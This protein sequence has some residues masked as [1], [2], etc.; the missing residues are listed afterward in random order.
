[1]LGDTGNSMEAVGEKIRADAYYAQSDGL[2][3]VAI[4]LQNFTGRIYIEATLISDPQE[5]DWFP[6]IL[7]GGSAYVE[8][9]LIPG[10]PSSGLQGDTMVDAFTFQGNFLY[11][12]ARMDKT[13]Y[14]PI[15]ASNAEK[16]L[17]G[18]ITKIMLNH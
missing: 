2:H 11:L 18:S 14:R 15:P 17:L 4:H 9:P 10:Q 6:I 7:S 12:R 16:A 3:S 1:M 5:N 8:Y 13:Y